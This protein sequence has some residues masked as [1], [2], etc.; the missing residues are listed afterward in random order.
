LEFNVYI[1]PTMDS[2]KT[3]LC[4]YIIINLNQAIKDVIHL[5]LFFV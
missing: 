5:F 1:S 3:T 2:V 4:N